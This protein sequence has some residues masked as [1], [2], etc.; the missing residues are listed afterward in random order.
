MIKNSPPTESFQ[1]NKKIRVKLSGDATNVGKR[2]HVV[3]VTFTILDEGSKA[4]SADGNHII[5]IIKEPENYEKLLEALSDIRGDWKFL[6]CICGLGAAISTHPCIWCKCPLYDN[7]DG[8]NEWS[9]VDTNKGARTIK[10]IEE[11]SKQGSRGEKC[12]VK[13]SPLFPT[14]PLDHVAIDS[15]HLFLRIADNLINL[16]ILEFWRLDA[17]DKKKTFNDGFERS[18]Y[19]HMA[20]MGI[21]NNIA[22]V[23]I[24][25]DDS[26]KPFAPQNLTHVTVII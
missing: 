15:L 5:A 22:E 3:N 2:L 26:F 23:S 1:Q 21:L 16:L 9:M 13:H 19:T 7:Y 10:E 18:K 17:I 6:A 4:M 24:D 8:T 14:I 25:I 12:N 11:K 20:W